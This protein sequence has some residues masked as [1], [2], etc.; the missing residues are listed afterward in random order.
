MGLLEALVTTAFVLSGVVLCVATV[1]IWRRQSVPATGE[2]ASVTAITGIGALALATSFTLGARSVVGVAVALAF[3]LPV[4]WLLFTFEYTG[5]DELN[6]PVT[7]VIISVPIVL[8]LISTVGIFSSQSFQSVVFWTSLSR[9]VVTVVTYTLSIMEGIMLL[10]A[11]GLML[12]GTGV[13]LWTFHQYEHL[14]PTSGMLFGVFGLVP[15][16]S[17]LFGFQVTRVDPL[18]LPAT[19]SV[20][21][22]VS[23]GAVGLVVRRKQAFRRLP[24][25]GNIGP[26]TVINELADI[27][28][29]TDS[30]GTVIDFNPAAEQ[31]IVSSGRSVLGSDATELLGRP[32]DELDTSDTVEV[33]SSEGRKLFDPTVSELTDQY[34]RLLGYAVS[35]RDVTDRTIR[36]QRLEVLNRIFRHNLR[37]D[38]NVLLGYG[39]VLTR[40]VEDPFLVKSAEAIVETSERIVGFSEVAGNIDRILRTADTAPRE[41]SIDEVVRDVLDSVPEGVTHDYEV[42]DGI[43][44]EVSKDLLEMALTELVENAHEHDDTDSPSVSVR[45]R[46]DPDDPYPLTVSVVDTGPG[47]PDVEQET[48]RAG[49]ETQLHHGSGLGLWVVHWAVTRLGGDLDI[50]ENEPRGT[51]VSIRLPQ[52][53]RT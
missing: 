37:N 8:G 29:V 25:A 4:P 40:G 24:A 12:V 52:A 26:A 32:P 43:V 20:G 2:F 51:V 11:G 23:A 48:I 19:V 30:Q 27:V 38:G 47:I 9:R 6:T 45:V 16:L 17:L 41:L 5:R 31:I 18:A 44:V 53:K 28:I 50:S 49:G 36:E 14:D 33:M 46:Y 15:W 7:L 22:L 34:G 3:L 1:A 10:Y 42:P 13:I 35:L 21:L 39:D